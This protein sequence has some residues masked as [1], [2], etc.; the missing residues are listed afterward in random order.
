M[1]APFLGI[2]VLHDSASRTVADARG[3]WPFKRIVVGPYFCKLSMQEQNAVLYHEAHHCNHFHF[4]LRLLLIALSSLP[5]VIVLPWQVLAAALT[6][7]G[8][9]AVALFIGRRQEFAADETAVRA[10]HGFGLLAFLRR[11]E[12]TV[13]S[14]KSHPSPQKRIERVIRLMKEMNDELA[15]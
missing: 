11:Y 6:S 4:E 12:A 2:P 5:M 14:V 7:I 13:I 15:A 3:S 1:M 8:L 9:W 10:G